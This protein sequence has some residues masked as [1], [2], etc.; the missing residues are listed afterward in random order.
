MRRLRDEASELLGLTRDVCFW[1]C[2]QFGPARL[3][4]GVSARGRGQR[5][6]LLCVWPACAG[7]VVV[8]QASLLG[9]RSLRCVGSLFIYMKRVSVSVV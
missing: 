2:S 9:S 7:F 1:R 3:A 5:A 6:G 8:V 4:G